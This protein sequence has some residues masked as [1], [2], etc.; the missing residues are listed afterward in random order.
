MCDSAALSYYS[1]KTISISRYKPATTS[2][3]Q[4]ENKE[5]SSICGIKSEPEKKYT[6]CH[7]KHRL[8]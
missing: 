5:R 3:T 4:A 6:I 1:L 2:R 7:L 8:Y